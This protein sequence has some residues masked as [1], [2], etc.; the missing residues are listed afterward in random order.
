MNL[1]QRTR[2]RR[3]AQWFYDRGQ[4]LYEAGRYR[5]AAKRF[6]RS[7]RR[8]PAWPIAH[9][10]R[11]LS[12]VQVRRTQRAVRNLE[13]AMALAAERGRFDGP[14]WLANAAYESGRTYE[15]LGQPYMA[16]RCYTKAVALTEDG[17]VLPAHEI[18]RRR[19]RVYLELGQLT[20]A[21]GDLNRAVALAPDNI[22]ARFDRAW[23]HIHLDNVPAAVEDLE[24]Y[25][26]LTDPT[27]V[28]RAE[29]Q[30]LLDE[31]IAD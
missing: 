28:R 14:E 25:V 10:G 19:G 22:L 9:A 8:S 3:N 23:A 4:Q 27:N 15:R 24:A 13:R 30:S 16:L 29:A 26:G 6:A 31:L 5:K 21:L 2:R 12:L 7:I 17:N 18:L 20:R 11:G 1:A